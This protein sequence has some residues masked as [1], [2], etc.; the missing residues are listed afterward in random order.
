MTRRSKEISSIS[1]VGRTE[2]FNL[3]VSRGQVAYHTPVEKFGVNHDITNTEETIWQQGGNYPWPASVQTMYVSSTSGDD[4]LGGTGVEKIKVF[5]LDVNYDEVSEEVELDGQTQ[6]ATANQY[7]RIFRAYATLAGSGGTSA[8]TIYIGT[9]PSVAGV[10]PV[11]YA[12]LGLSNQTQLALYTVPSNTTFYLNNVGFTAAIAQALNNVTASVRIREF[13]TNVWRVI[14]TQQ[15]RDNLLFLHFDYP[16]A[17]PEKTDIEMRGISTTTGV[18][19]V[20]VSGEFEGVNIWNGD[21]L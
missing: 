17:I 6:V 20:T 8:G 9:A 15:L 3:Q 2:P 13:G 7:I 10:P 16:L 11:V 1:R 18:N 14:I 19:G 5:G 12:N 4:A 21:V